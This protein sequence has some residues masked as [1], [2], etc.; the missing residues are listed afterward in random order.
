MLI[1]NYLSNV[2]G[3]YGHTQ[4]ACLDNNI[5][6]YYVEYKYNIIILLNIKYNALI[7]SIE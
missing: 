1:F 6:I 2:F 7:Y 3:K 5:R 4:H